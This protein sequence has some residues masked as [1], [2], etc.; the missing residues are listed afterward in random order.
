MLVWASL[1]EVCRLQSG[2]EPSELIWALM[3]RLALEQRIL[4][5]V[6][7]PNLQVADLLRLEGYY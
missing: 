5:P 3:V 2:M 6:E 4:M 1:Q 7:E